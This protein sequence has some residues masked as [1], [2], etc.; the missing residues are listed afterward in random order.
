VSSRRY[1]RSS[2]DLV[3]ALTATPISSRPAP[4]ATT[5]HVR[6]MVGGPGTSEQNIP[7]DVTGTVLFRC[8]F[9]RFVAVLGDDV[10]A[11]T[12]TFALACR[13]SGSAANVFNS[14]TLAVCNPDG[15]LIGAVIDPN[16]DVNA[17]SEFSNTAEQGLVFTSAGAA[18][19]GVTPGESLLVF[20]W[21]T[22]AVQGSAGTRTA[23][24]YYNGT[25]DPVN[26][27][28]LTSAASYIETT[29]DG[30]FDIASTGGGGV[31]AQVIG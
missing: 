10:D 23:R 28:G 29:Q 24:C 27:V 21:W 16:P 17:G 26:G 25:D 2:S 12:W 8:L 1:P 14:P 5:G 20:E 30:L 9:G 6:D 18:V 31:T 11:A 13:E 19:S 3:G 4:D 22:R 7:L 15:S